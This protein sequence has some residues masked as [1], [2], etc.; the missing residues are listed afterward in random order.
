MSDRPAWKLIQ[1]QIASRRALRRGSSTGECFLP[2]GA[3]RSETYR[4][5]TAGSTGGS[6]AR[7]APVQESA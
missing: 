2:V 5:W 4:G 7:P 1:R 3:G 6:E